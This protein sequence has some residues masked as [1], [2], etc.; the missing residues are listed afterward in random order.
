MF[1]AIAVTVAISA[2]VFLPLGALYGHSVAAHVSAEASA[3]KAHVTATFATVK[4]DAQAGLADVA[5][6]L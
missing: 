4:A 6:K 2:V 5:K 3:V 1:E